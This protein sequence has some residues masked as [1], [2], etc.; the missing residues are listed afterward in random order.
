MVVSRLPLLALFALLLTLLA[1]ATIAAQQPPPPRERTRIGITAIGAEGAQRVNLGRI[2]AS[3]SNILLESHPDALFVNAPSERFVA[4]GEPDFVAADEEILDLLILITLE[5]PRGEEEQ[6]LTVQLF[7]VR[8]AELIAAER[9]TVSIGRLGRYIRSSSW[10]ELVAGLDPFIDAYRPFTEVV[11]RTEG[12][13]RVSWSEEGSVL[14]SDDG[15]AVVRL[16]NMRSY[17][18]TAEAE[19]YRTDSISLFVE[20]KPMEVGLDLLRYPQWMVELTLADA[21]FPRVGGGRFFRDTSLFLYGELTTRGFGFTPFRWEE[22]P[23]VDDEGEPKL[24]SS[25]PVSELGLGADLYL[26]DRDRLTRLSLGAQLI[27]R[28]VHADYYTGFDPILPAA[29]GLR[30]GLQREL[31]EHFF[32]VANLDSRF[33]WVRRASFSTPY[34]MYYQLGTL[35]ML[36]QPAVFSF[37]GRYAP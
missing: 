29:L 27:G 24:F 21:S 37:G 22:D 8:A 17:T 28:F 10:E 32:L 13:A 5:A 15:R 4:D 6:P 19:G 33:Y 36:W 7:D 20:R 16:R 34:D 23:E 11:V 35:P 1:P 3:A 31:G 9:T 30:F 18:I 14:A 26:S 12:G 25:F 2:R